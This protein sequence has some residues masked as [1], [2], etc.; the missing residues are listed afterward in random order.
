MKLSAIK[1]VNPTSLRKNPENEKY[2][3]LL[4][5]KEFQRLAE[6]IRKNGIKVPLVAKQDGT[7]LAGHNRLLIA[8]TLKLKAVP[9]SVS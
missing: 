7:L 1:Q 9:V 6:D 4:Q 2:F 3:D 8:K 5:G